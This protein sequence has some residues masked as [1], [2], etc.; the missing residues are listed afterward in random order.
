MTDTSH[1]LRTGEPPSEPAARTYSTP[2]RLTSHEPATTDPLPPAHTESPVRSTARGK[3]AHLR[4]ALVIVLT[5]CVA[6]A[7]LFLFRPLGLGG[8][9]GYVVVAGNSM[10]PTYQTGD[11]VITRST[12]TYEVGDVVAFRI[13]DDGSGSRPVVIHRIIGGDATEGYVLQGDNNDHRDLWRPLPQDVLGRAWLHIPHGG[14]AL[15]APRSPLVLAT[16]TAVFAFLA[17]AHVPST[18]RPSTL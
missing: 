11:L 3:A 10:Q 6:L 13:P 18:R 9:T 16:L 15:A 14:V 12:P 1:L 2:A 17:V 7:W 8:M 5:P 4:R